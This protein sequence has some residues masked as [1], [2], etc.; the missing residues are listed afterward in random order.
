IAG[1]GS[2]WWSGP[3]AGPAGSRPSGWPSASATSAP[4]VDLSFSKARKRACWKASSGVLILALDT[5]TSTATC[6]LVRDG[7]V[8]GEGTGSAATVLAEAARLLENAGARPQ[9]LNALAVGVG[10][11]SFTGIRIGLAAA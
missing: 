11:G 2:A 6:A 10:P 5:V 7:E 1:G 3:R 9:D 4:S 8:L